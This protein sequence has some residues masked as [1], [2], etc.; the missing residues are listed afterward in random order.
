M[1][2]NYWWGQK[3]DERK[4]QWMNW[5]KLSKLKDG[6]RMGFRD[7]KLFNL[8]L[9]AKQGWQLIQ[10]LHSLLFRVLKSKYFPNTSFM[11]API[12]IHSSYT[13]RSIAQAR[14]VIYQGARWC[15][16]SNLGDKWLPTPTTHQ[17]VSLC[18]VLNGDAPINELLMWTQ[19]NGTRPL[20]TPYSYPLK[21][22]SQ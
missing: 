22:R 3:G 1:I 19:N 8:A 2:S 5:A 20:L 15:K 16:G 11:E 4:I 10:K 7:L 18:R 9:L 17:V 6:G 12:P 14:E 21:L 13:W